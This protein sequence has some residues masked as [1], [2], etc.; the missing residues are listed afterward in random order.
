MN[1]LIWLEKYSIGHNKIDN[2]HKY[3]FNLV[4]FIIERK[5]FNSENLQ[6]L[7]NNLIYYASIHFH[8]EELLMIEIEYPNYINHRKKHEDFIHN[9]EKIE[10]RILIKDENILN[11]IIDFLSEWLINHIIVMDKSIEPLISNIP[12]K[13][14]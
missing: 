10:Y 1:K 7:F 6:E 8:E 5:N 2:Q 9:L 3:L 13:N 11:D 12:V 4:N 14:Y